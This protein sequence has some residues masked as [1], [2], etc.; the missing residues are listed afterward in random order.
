[1]SGAA[2]KPTTRL[3][4]AGSRGV[5]TDVVV[6]A[7]MNLG[8]VSVWALYVHWTG[9]DYWGAGCCGRLLLAFLFNC[10]W[11]VGRLTSGFKSGQLAAVG[12]QL[13][14][15]IDGGVYVFQIWDW[16]GG[17]AE[18]HMLYPW[19]VC[20]HWGVAARYAAQP[21]MPRRV[22]PSEPWDD[23]YEQ[24]HLSAVLTAWLAWREAAIRCWYEGRLK[25]T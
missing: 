11:G 7:L 16:G 17:S 12:Q 19:R 1:V 21:C 8:V 13:A 20:M 6:R 4:H 24:P 10:P 18:F 22:R 23:I 14:A 2:G 15:I 3:V 25:A 5:D 9:L